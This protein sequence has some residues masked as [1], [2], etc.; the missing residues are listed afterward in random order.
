MPGWFSRAAASASRAARSSSPSPAGRR[1]D[2][3]RDVAVE[4]LVTR[5]EH[6]PEAARAEP[7]PEPV[8]AQDERAAV[9]E[10]SAGQLRGRVHGPRFDVRRRIP[11][12]GPSD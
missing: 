7:L 5:G 11:A 3:D 2:L 4:P 6:R 8:A 12:G 9:L 10:L 1:D